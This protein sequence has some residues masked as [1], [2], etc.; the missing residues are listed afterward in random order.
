MKLDLDNAGVVIPRPIRGDG[1]ARTGVVMDEESWI[2]GS[3]AQHPKVGIS[4]IDEGD[5]LGD[6]R[7][8]SDGHVTKI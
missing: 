8:C 1:P 2:V 7:I 4:A 5:L 6:K 3:D